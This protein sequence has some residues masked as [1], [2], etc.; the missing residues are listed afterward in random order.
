MIWAGSDDGLVHVTRDGGKTWK[1]VTPKG[2]PEWMQINSIDASPLDKGDAPTSPPRCTSR[3]TSAPISTR[4][5]TTA[6]P[7]RGSTTA[8]TADH[9]TRVVRADPERRGLLYAGTERGIYVSFDDGARWQPLQLNLPIV[10]VHRP[11]DQGRRPDRRHPGARLL[12]PRRPRAAAPSSPPST[13]SRRDS[14]PRS[15]RPLRPTA[16]RDAWLRRLPA[17]AGMGQNP[18]AGV[19]DRLLPE[20]GAAGRPGEGGQARD[21]RPR[22]AR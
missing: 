2:L 19:V 17:A 13:T 6:R 1:N 5:P 3:T 4:R 15:S 10:P 11:D 22:T 14:S 8:S 16:S 7:G 20:R 9:F 21:P 18:P 12:D